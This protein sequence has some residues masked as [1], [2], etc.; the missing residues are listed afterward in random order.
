MAI[1]PSVSKVLDKANLKQY[2]NRFTSA[3]ITSTSDLVDAD[4]E[5]LE[6]LGL[7]KFQRKKLQRVVSNEVGNTTDKEEN[8][9]Y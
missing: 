7:S 1:R 9:K 5:D 4:A 8:L 6:E 3:G 2:E